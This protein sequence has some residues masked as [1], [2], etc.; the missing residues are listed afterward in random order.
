M[1]QVYSFGL[2][3]LF[4]VITTVSLA[5]RRFAARV[6]SFSSEYSPSAWSASKTLGAPTISNCGDNSE[7]WASSSSDARR[8]FLV[9]EY[10]DPA[11]VNRIFIYET[12]S[13]GAVD[14]V[15]VLNPHT[16]AYEKVYEA[17]A[18]ASASCPRQLTISFPVTSFPVS[19]IRIAINSP[20]VGGFNEID[21]VGIAFISEGGTIGTSQNVCSSAPASAFTSID[22]AFNGSAGAQ[23]QWQESTDNNNWT[24]IPAATNITYQAPVVSQ[25][26]WYR[27]KASLA[28]DIAFSNTIKLT[29]ASP[30]DPSVI[31]VNSWNF[32]TYQSTDLNLGNVVYKGFYNL[33]AISFDTREQWPMN[34]TPA[35]STGYQGCQ[36][37]NNQFV[38]AARRKGFPAGNYM[39]QIRNFRGQ[40]RVIV[41]GVAFPDMSCC[42]AALSIGALDQN[43]V[44]EIRLL[45]Y[46]EAYIDVDF[47]V[48]ELNGGDIG[49]SQNICS[50]DM[51]AAFQNYI[52]AFGGAAPS[53]ITYQWQDS[54]ANGNW[55]NIANATGL[56]YQPVTLN[57]TTWFRR[58]VKD[59][60]NATAYSDEVK[61]T[62]S[63]PAGDTAVYGNQ[64][65]NLYAFQGTDMSLTGVRY[66]GYYTING[67]AF[68]TSDHW[69]SEQSPSSA[70]NYTGCPVAIDNFIVSARRTGFPTGM[71]RLNI[72]AADEHVIVFLDGVEMYNGICC[73]NINLG[74]LDANS[75]VEIRNKETGYVSWLT[76]DFVRS[77]GSIADYP[78]NNSCNTYKLSNITGNNWIDITGADGKIIA[79]INPNGKNLGTVTM[80]VLHSTPGPANIPTNPV[81]DKRY[82]PRYFN[83]ISSNYPSGIFPSPVGL[84]LY[85]K[86]SELDDYKTITNQPALTKEELRVA[87]YDGAAEDCS[88]ANNANQGVML[89]A[90]IATNFT[91]AGFCLEASTS[92]FSEFGVVG[93]TQVLPVTLTSFKANIVDGKVQL[94]W[95]T[96]QEL[97]NKGFEVLRSRGGQRFEKIGWVDGNGTTN[98]PQQYAFTD[99]SPISG[100]SFYRLR[101]VDIDGNSK[102]T[103]I[104][105][106]TTK[107]MLRFNISPNPVENILYLELDEKKVTYVRITDMQGRI[108]WQRNGRPASSVL[109]IPVQQ[110]NRGVYFL[111]IGDETGNHRTGKFVRK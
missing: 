65:W 28:G 101:Q 43:S 64:S 3:F 9:L 94:S 85:Y 75:K 105:G 62:V 109:R 49:N 74:L 2:C 111:E 103:D 81:N 100:K 77:D 55:N 95:A 30:G 58:M 71:Y 60:T 51:P 44:I 5:Q 96:S 70:A 39:M 7:A 19:R 86:N 29:I 27:R 92:S 24:D 82:L 42:S 78:G 40:L 56:V 47:V 54:V 99:A 1:R 6:L 16:N 66:R 107:E 50:N 97:N 34:G 52:A 8:E 57:T 72:S 32:Y 38:V 67:L 90:P 61:V 33:A 26:T 4:S 10:D 46:G 11:P 91:A 104:Y 45:D 35:S 15:Y 23:Y 79:S 102:L 48:T 73:T 53:S 93:G 68:A 69:H 17:T 18:A 110:L 108:L 89:A 22:P 36:P 12:L 41:N 14:T 87:H 20:A 106:V 83:F 98:M 84:R 21:A 63:T 80:N 25:D 59:N 31:P 13:P 88:M 76:V 37:P